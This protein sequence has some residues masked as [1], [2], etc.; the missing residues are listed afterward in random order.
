M[1]LIRF[2]KWSSLERPVL[3]TGAIEGTSELYNPATG[4]GQSLAA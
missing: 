1:C 2:V 4:T 3:M